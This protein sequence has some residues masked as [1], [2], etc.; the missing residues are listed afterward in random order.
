MECLSARFRE[1]VVAVLRSDQAVLATIALRGD[2]F[3][4]SLKARP[5]VNLVRVTQQNRD[6]LV[7]Q[8]V[9]QVQEVLAGA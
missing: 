6:Q 4:E 9:D 8:T 5:D 1:L 2:R 3:I 7:G